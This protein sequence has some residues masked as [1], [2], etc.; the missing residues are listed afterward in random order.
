M[1][2]RQL[3]EANL[4]K[5]DRVIF[6]IEKNDEQSRHELFT[7]FYRRTFGIVYHILRNRENA[8]DITQDAFVR[9]FQELH[10]LREPAKFGA[11]LAAIASNL[12]RNHLKREKRIVLIEDYETVF[13]DAAAGAEEQAI[14]VMDLAKVREAVKGL[15]PDQYQVLVLRYYYDLKVEEI[16]EMLK[17]SAGTVKSRLFRARQKI[18][19]TLEPVRGENCL[20]CKGGEED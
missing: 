19:R 10:R 3:R 6:L 17:V 5:R 7:E 11:W 1:V 8:E 15:P 16:A 9:A 14:K 12:A 18:S 13:K 2:F 20:S 4:L